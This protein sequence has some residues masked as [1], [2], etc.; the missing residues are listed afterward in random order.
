MSCVSTSPRI[1]PTFTPGPWLSRRYAAKRALEEKH[2][3]ER[4][5][6]ARHKDSS[7]VTT[8]KGRGSME[9][10]PL[11]VLLGALVGSWFRNR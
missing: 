2:L 6:Q 9:W 3:Q 8:R 4:A 5:S 10:N 11:A 1:P 7:R